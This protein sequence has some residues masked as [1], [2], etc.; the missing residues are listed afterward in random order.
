MNEVRP[1][2][3]AGLFYPGSARE[4]RPM[5][6]D[7]FD[8]ESAASPNP[9]TKAIIAPHAGY[10]YSGPIAASA[11]HC[12]AADA[13]DI[14]RIVLLGPAHRVLVQGLALPAAEAFETP[15]RNCAHRS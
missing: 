2:A 9:V 3:V 12:F 13:G 15:P 8:S 7:L 4:L 1:A 14:D 6:E 5:V 10:V 11:F